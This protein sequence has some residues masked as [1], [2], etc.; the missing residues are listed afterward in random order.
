[1]EVFAGFLEH[2][3]YE[4]G[5]VLAALQEMGQMDNTLIIVSSDN[6]ASAEGGLVG[7]TNEFRIFNRVPEDIA[8]DLKRIDEFA[9]PFTYEYYPLG[10]TQATNPPLKYYNPP[11]HSAPL[12]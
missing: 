8:R 7:T 9:S 10:W 1:M 11:S 3:D 6:G 5:R 12:P 4:F 2:A